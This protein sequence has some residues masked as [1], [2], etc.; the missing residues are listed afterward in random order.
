[1]VRHPKER[2]I[3]T[4]SSFLSLLITIQYCGAF[5]SQ[6]THFHKI[7]QNFYYGTKLKGSAGDLYEAVHRKEY[8]MRALKKEHE[9]PSS[10]LKVAMSYLEESVPP[11]RL[12]RALRRVY[13]D[14]ENTANPN[15]VASEEDSSEDSSEGKGA[16]DPTYQNTLNMRRGCFVADIKRKSL[17][18]P[19]ETFCRFDDAGSVAVA[20]V[21]MGADCVFVNIDYGSY[22]GDLSEL[23]S[24]VRAVRKVSKTAAV[25]MKDVIVDEIQIGLAK[26]AG[27]DGVLLIASVLGPALE[28]FLN[29][30]A[31]VGMESIVECHTKNEIEAA[32]DSLAQNILVSNYDRIRGEYFPDQAFN[33]A[34]LFPGS[35][36]PIICLAGGD[37]QSEEH[38]KEALSAG[39]DGVV[40]GKAIMGNARA[41]EFITAVKD[42]VMLPTEFSGWDLDDDNVEYD[43]NGN[44][45]FKDEK[46]KIE[47]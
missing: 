6:I 46:T 27:C 12:A 34:G 38:V 29:L 23:R 41:P 32:L 40:V 31:I 8:E 33:L 7:P 10:P 17:S 39:Y 21:E 25:V 30:C 43:M 15:Y 28:N 35:G 37:I 9:S 2:I 36:G 18:R 4:A 45:F 11:L 13:E 1:M 26:D 19:G 5:P 3:I 47:K 24:A 14:P 44:V 42:R 16:E 20:M 22:G